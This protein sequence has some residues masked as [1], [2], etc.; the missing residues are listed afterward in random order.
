MIAFLDLRTHL[1]FIDLIATSGKLFFAV[2]GLSY[3]HWLALGFNIF[4]QFNSSDGGTIVAG[5]SEKR[6]W[7]GSTLTQLTIYPE[8]R[9]E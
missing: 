4:L 8:E 7:L 3:C 6:E 5:R 2:A 1:R 9:G